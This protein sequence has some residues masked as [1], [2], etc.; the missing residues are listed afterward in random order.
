MDLNIDFETIYYNNKY[1]QN[2]PEWLQ[3]IANHI[4]EK[5]KLVGD[6]EIYTLIGISETNEDYYYYVEDDNGNRHF[7]SCVGK[8]EFIE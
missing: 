4:G 8:I 7:D 2:L 5:C 6:E 3:E 1:T